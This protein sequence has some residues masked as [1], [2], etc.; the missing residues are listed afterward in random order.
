MGKR[1]ELGKEIKSELVEVVIY[2]NSGWLF[3]VN[4][5]FWEEDGGDVYCVCV[6]M[7]EKECM[8]YRFIGLQQSSLGEIYPNSFE[9]VYMLEF[10]V[11]LC[12]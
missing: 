9:V 10:E 8:L 4:K 2:F 11:N 3:K 12:C 5:G 7:C 6:C 1:K